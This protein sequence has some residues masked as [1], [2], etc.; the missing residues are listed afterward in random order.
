MYSSPYP[1][2]PSLWHRAVL[3]AGWTVGGLVAPWILAFPPVTY[4]G[5]GLFAAYGWGV[6]FGAGAL[7][8][9]TGHLFE[10]HRIE[11]PG[12]GLVLGGLVLYLLLSW[13]QVFTGTTGSGSRA[14]LLV[15]FAAERLARGL[16]LAG[17]D[18]SIRRLERLARGTENVG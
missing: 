5:L 3:V 17:H 6:M 18:R 16:R 2:P 8:I 15:P 12:V 14:L 11:I 13:H 9:A 1:V 10:A 7:L 4:Q